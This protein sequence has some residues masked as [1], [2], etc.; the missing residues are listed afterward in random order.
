MAVW[1][2]AKLTFKEAA[3]RRIVLAALALGLLFLAVYGFGLRAIFQ[4]LAA[5]SNGNPME[6]RAASDFLFLAG[7]YV[8]NFMVV[9]LSVLTS[10]DTVSGEIAS[11]TMHTL[12]SKPIPRWQIFAGK[13]LGFVFMITLYLVFMASGVLILVDH[14]GH[15]L[16]PAAKLM[17][18]LPLVWLNGQ[19]ALAMSLAGGTRLSTLANGVMAFGLYG[20]AFVGGWI[21]QIGAI[22]KNDTAVN[23]G[24]ASSLLLPSEALWRMAVGRMQS[25]IVSELGISPFGSFS[26]PSTAMA[27]YAVGYVVVA[28][29]AAAW[30]FGRRDL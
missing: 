26:Q 3:R 29:I 13:W 24:I 21:E 30:M 25:S 23:V 11:G 22:L 4:E 9:I 12:A 14:F 10:V 2:I 1:T 15:S 16:P 19:L 6:R 8:V 27:V 18:G 7:F 20:V 5:E 28:W 17:R